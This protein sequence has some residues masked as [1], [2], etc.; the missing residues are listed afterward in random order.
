MRGDLIM[1]E[2]DQPKPQ[3]KPGRKKGSFIGD[4]PKTG[5]LVIACTEEECQKI[6]QLAQAQG[7]S[8]SRFVVDCILNS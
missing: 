1:T 4:A 2:L 6:K 3:S 8:V 5:R 7:K